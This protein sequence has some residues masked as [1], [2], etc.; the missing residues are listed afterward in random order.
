MSGLSFL[1]SKFDGI[2]GMAFSAISID[3]IP[4]VFQVLMDE[5]KVQDGS[6]A[7]FLTDKAGEEG[8]ALVLGGVDP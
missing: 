6:F 4:P 2:L 7:F 1:A 3:N 8:S 5:G